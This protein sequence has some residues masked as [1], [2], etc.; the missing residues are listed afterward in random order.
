[1]PFNSLLWAMSTQKYECKLLM[2]EEVYFKL[3]MFCQIQ[4]GF[5]ENDVGFENYSVKY[6]HTSFYCTLQILH[7]LQTEGL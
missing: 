4:V 1:M 2:K 3:Q 7:F 6:R 5:A